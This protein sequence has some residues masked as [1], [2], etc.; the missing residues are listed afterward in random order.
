MSKKGKFICCSFIYILMNFDILVVF[1]FI[2]PSSFKKSW[3]RRWPK[4][5]GDFPKQIFRMEEKCTKNKLCITHTHTHTSRNLFNKYQS[6]YNNKTIFILNC[7]NLF[8]TKYVL[9][10][11]TPFVH[12]LLMDKN[13]F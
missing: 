12:R 10:A 6:F 13:M 3:L 11:S 8:P 2:S 5:M 1:F 7:Y 9:L 4:V